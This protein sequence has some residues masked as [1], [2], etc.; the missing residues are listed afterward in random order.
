MDSEL[1]GN[2]RYSQ[3][4]QFIKTKTTQTEV[5]YEGE[6]LS[7]GI[8]VKDDQVY[9][10]NDTLRIVQEGY[11]KPI[12]KE[13]PGLKGVKKIDSAVRYYWDD[14][15]YFYVGLEYYVWEDAS[16]QIDGP[17]VISYDWK[18]LCLDYFK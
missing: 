5:A 18:H 12:E 4:I 16:S 6:R 9:L 2:P 10:Y 15:I 13:F 14:V 17:Y 8:L 7:F 11:P 1:T 3:D